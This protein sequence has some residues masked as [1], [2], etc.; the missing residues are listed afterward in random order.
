[1]E[2]TALWL[3]LLLLALVSCRPDAVS[4]HVHGAFVCEPIGL[5]LCLELPYNMTFMPNLLGH[6]DQQTAAVAME[7]FHPLLK[8]ECSPEARTFLCAMFAPACAPPGRVVPPCRSLCGRVRDSCAELREVFG[9]PWPDEMDCG[10]LEECDEPYPMS[11][12]PVASGATPQTTQ[13]LAQRDYGFWCPRE[14]KVPSGLGYSFMGVPDCSPPCPNMYFSSGELELTRYLVGVMSVVC[15]VATTFTFLTFLLDRKRFR[16][17]ERPIIFYATCYVA[18]SLSF[19]VGFLL[20]DSAAAC[21]APGLAPGAAATVTQGSRNNK[22]CTA[23]FMLLYFSA[24]AGALWWVVLTITWF[25]AAGLKWGREAIE[26]RAAAFHALA[27]GPPAALTVALLALNKVEGD[28]LS[29]VCFAGL[30]DV[31]TLRYFVLAPLGVCAAA[32]LSLLLAGIVSLNRV[33]LEMRHDG[34]NQT[35]LV[36]FMVRIGVFS[37]LYLVPQL[38]LVACL[39]Y[40]QAS[41]AAW[42]ATWLRDRCTEYR[43]PCPYQANQPKQRPALVLFLVKYFTTLV[44]GI[45]PAFW[46]G[47]RKTCLGWA[48]FLSG[49]RHKQAVVNE[50]RRVL[51]ESHDVCSQ[52]LLASAPRKSRGTSTQGTSTHASS[53]NALE[54]AATSPPPPPPGLCGSSSKPSSQHSRVSGTHGK[55][56]DARHTPNSRRSATVLPSPARHNSCKSNSNSRELPGQPRHI[57]LGA[58][59]PHHH[60]HQDSTSA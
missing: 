48:A 26:K 22:A 46:V 39:V 16:Y 23:V 33:R 18:V 28:N 32:G 41:R 2:R 29:G 57:T 35:K 7:P 54:E 34:R 8:L 3:M 59:S 40:E 4:S 44:V 53:S 24:M 1:M 36:K 42:E 15:L 5:R 19:L 45:P 25:L 12:R 38:A 56:P 52:T 10:R 43:I 58:N 31:T 20:D 51:E 17:P 60:H 37:V 6:Y 11:P 47:S 49:R 27:W 30:Y 55:P 14:L 50:S 9:I 13:H 21:N